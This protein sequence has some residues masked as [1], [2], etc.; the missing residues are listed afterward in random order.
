[1]DCV[2]CIRSDVKR[3]VYSTAY[4]LN[5]LVILAA[6]VAGTSQERAWLVFRPLCAFRNEDR[7]QRTASR[8]AALA[9]PPSSYSEGIMSKLVSH[10]IAALGAAVL[11]SVA[12]CGDRPGPTAPS[13]TRQNG[14]AVPPQVPPGPPAD[15]GKPAN[16]SFVVTLTSLVV[17]TT[18]QLEVQ[19]VDKK[20]APVAGRPVTWS[21]TNDGGSAGSF[22]PAQGVTDASGRVSTTFTAGTSAAAEHVTATSGTKSATIAVAVLPG[23]ATNLVKVGTEANGEPRLQCTLALLAV[24]VTDQYGNGIA[25]HNVSWYLATQPQVITNTTTVTGG[26]ASVNWAPFTLGLQTTVASAISQSE[27]P[28]IGSPVQFSFTVIEETDPTSECP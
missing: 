21:S 1:M 22:D 24:R 5:P 13:A 12:A 4:P 19:V 9:F 16:I 3:I 20:G 27:A 10:P 23:P 15:A 11:I 2:F 18:G 28:L 6:A 7:S 8:F 14:I 17:N 26:F 25:G